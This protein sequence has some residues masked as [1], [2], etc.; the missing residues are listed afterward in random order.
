M[1]HYNDYE[2]IYLIQSEGIEEALVIMINKYKFMI[3]KY[4][5]LYKVRE[6][7]HED[8]IQEGNI[9]INYSILK[10]DEKKGKSFTRFFEL[11][12]KRRFYKLNSDRPKYELTDKIDSY[13]DYN[14]YD[15]EIEITDL[16]ELEKHVFKHYFVENKKIIYIA[17]VEEK[18]VKQIYNAIYR[19]KEKYKNYML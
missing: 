19:I 18:S 7:D 11:L 14:E 12:L 10:F 3:Y 17:E 13:R 4:L 1:H 5:Y 8:F 16:T 15:K 9:L 2:L 6:V